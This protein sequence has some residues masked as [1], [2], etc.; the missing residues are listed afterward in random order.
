MSTVLRYISGMTAW[1]SATTTLVACQEFS[2]SGNWWL[3]AA[4]IALSVV[5]WAA[6]DW[7]VAIRKRGEAN[8]STARK[9]ENQGA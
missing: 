3:I 7:Q 9:S 6:L 1:A 4:A 5:F 8:V 2:K